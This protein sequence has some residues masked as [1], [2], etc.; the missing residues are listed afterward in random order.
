M[1]T[2]L[3]VGSTLRERYV[4]EGVVFSSEKTAVYLVFDKKITAKRWIIKEFTFTEE[5]PEDEIIS[6]RETLIETVDLLRVYEHKNLAKVLEYFTF[7]QKDYIVMEYIEGDTFLEFAQKNEQIEEKK[8]IDWAIQIC[9]ALHYLN[10]R[11]CPYIFGFLDPTRIVI[12]K[13]GTVKL[14]NYGLGRFFGQVEPTCFSKD[15]IYFTRQLNS[16]GE[17]LIFLATKQK[18]TD[19]SVLEKSSL[20]AEAKKI[21]EKCLDLKAHTLYSSFEEVGLLYKNLIEAPAEISAKKS[22]L[23]LLKE[24]I[25]VKINNLVFA[26]CRQKVQYAALEIIG[27]IVFFLAVY[28][29]LNPIYKFTKKGP[30]VYILCANN[31]ILCV[32][33]GSQKTLDKITLTEPAN[34]IKGDAINQKLYMSVESAP[35]SKIKAINCKNNKPDTLFNVTVDV[36][37][38]NILID[39][40]NIFLYVLNKKTNNISVINMNK[41]KMVKLIST[42]KNA[43]DIKDSAAQPFLFVASVKPDLVS[44][45][46]K[47]TDKVLLTLECFGTP[48]C[49]SVSKEKTEFF[50]AC[51]TLNSV[52]SYELYYDYKNELSYKMSAFNDIGGKGPAAIHLNEKDGCF[53]VANKNSNNVSIIDIKNNKLRRSIKVGKSPVDMIFIEPNYLWVLN[54]GS[55]EV[56]IIDTYTNTLYK[57]F[58]VGKKPKC[59]TYVP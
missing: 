35:N 36:D 49:I 59:I 40:R 13:D 24:K 27:V 9:D 25:S 44:V 58:P 42:E 8:I 6:R 29:I 4:I 21:I 3:K 15:E 20:S 39:K 17:L 55:D 22:A 51:Q 14:I 47:N 54:Q 37:P 7:N 34:F 46:D 43:A 10:N 28:G 12:S 18:T 30:A 1:S 16:L 56:T 26:F 31:E 45:I 23:T 57:R 53:Y 19:I 2:I 33:P 5:L 52:K 50:V 38:Q 48:I 41:R 32:D 11:P